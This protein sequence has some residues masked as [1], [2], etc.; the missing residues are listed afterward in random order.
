MFPTPGNDEEL[1]SYFESMNETCYKS[2]ERAFKLLWG[3]RR[4][5]NVQPDSD[6]DGIPYLTERNFT[7]NIKFVINQESEFFGKL[8]YLHF[9]NGKDKYKVTIQRFFE[10]LKTYTDESDKLSMHKTSFSI[11]D[12]DN[13]GKLN[14][15]NLLHL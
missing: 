10:G 8:L 3:W 2:I 4:P 11:L 1:A 12:L 14:V 7:K 6:M 13:D 15:I 9:S 5:E